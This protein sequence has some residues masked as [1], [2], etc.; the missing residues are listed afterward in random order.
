MKLLLCD[1]SCGSARNPEVFKC[2]SG[3]VELGLGLV[4]LDYLTEGQESPFSLST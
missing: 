1:N 3:V 2:S 4:A